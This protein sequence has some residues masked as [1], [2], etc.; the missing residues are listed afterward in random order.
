MNRIVNGEE[1]VANSRPWMVSIQDQSGKKKYYKVSRDPG[2]IRC[3]S[4]YESVGQGIWDNP[5]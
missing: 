5:Y 1:S 3:Y 2:M 4:L